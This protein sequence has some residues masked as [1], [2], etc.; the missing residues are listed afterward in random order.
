MSKAFTTNRRNVLKSAA[1]MASVSILPSSM[2]F[3]QN[4][5]SEQFRFAQVGC[6]G[7]G[8]SDMNSTIG[9]G[10]KLVAMCDVDKKR[11]GQ[12]ITKNSDIPIYDDYRVM[13][14][15]H[16]K[17]IDGVV[18]ST[19]D[20]THACI[21]LEAIK[22]GK[23]VYVQKPLAR[24]YDECK[25]LLEAANK[26]GV[27]TQMGNQGH[28]GDGL[29]LWKKMQEDN[30]FGDIQHINTWSNRPVWPQGMTKLPAP[31]TAPDTL[32]WDLWLGPQSDRSYAKEYL[33][34][35]WRGWWDFGA[36]AMGDMACHNMDPAFWIFELGLPSSVKATASAP[37]THAYPSWSIIEYKFDKSPVTGKPMTLTWFDGKKLPEMP[38]GAHPKLKA[39]GNGCMVIGSK[40][41]AMG[42]SHAGRPRPIALG[43]DEYS[44]AVK[45]AERH[46]RS[47]A[48]KFKGHN[49]YGEWIE[50]AK[51]GKKNAP[52]SSFDYSVPFTQAILI[53]CIALRFPGVELK[54]DNDKKQFSN[55]EEANKW[56]AF[57]ARD[58]FAITL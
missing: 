49:H 52:G 47:E 37:S 38:K 1:G 45:D 21:A 53:G 33:P 13:L 32:N 2:L 22:R 46:W 4:T 58:G 3:G 29:K 23:H 6:G 12:A 30:A 20:H 56:L 7:K 18:V 42:G 14:D 40:M 16:D 31:Q 8:W 51:A 25:V 27:T 26:Y 36:G 28:S 50:A 34:F 43:N 55:H 57:K 48:K 19:P 9:A 39:G 35:N 41:T 44:S 5:P 17:D 11:A 24:T 54:W 15:K 10:G